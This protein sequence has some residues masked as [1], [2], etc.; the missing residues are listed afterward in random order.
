MILEFQLVQF[1]RNTSE[2]TERIEEG[3]M[4]DSLHLLQV[5]VLHP[6]VT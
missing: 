6:S 2:L 5:F 4:H 3:D 1:Q